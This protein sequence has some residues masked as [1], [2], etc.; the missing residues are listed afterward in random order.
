MRNSVYLEEKTNALLKALKFFAASQDA[1]KRRIVF[2][3]QI[4]FWDWEVAELIYTFDKFPER[5][6]QWENLTKNL[7]RNSKPDSLLMILNQKAVDKAI[8]NYSDKE[9]VFAP[10]H[11]LK[12]VIEQW[13]ELLD[14]C[15]KT[16][17]DFDKY[18]EI[19]K[20]PKQVLGTYKKDLK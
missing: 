2:L 9:Q 4:D 10:V 7:V 13:N 8:F 17:L 19:S 20:D 16:C 11:L 6:D 14:I 1:Y 15:E 5:H 18:E 12:Q 3:Q